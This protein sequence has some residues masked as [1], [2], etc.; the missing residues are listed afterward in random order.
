MSLLVLG[1]TKL[2]GRALVEAALAAGDRG[3][4]ARPDGAVHVLGLLGVTPQEVPLWFPDGDGWSRVDAGRAPAAGLRLRSLGDTVAAARQQ[5]PLVDGIGL[6]P[7]REAELL[8][9][10]HAR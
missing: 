3:R 1:G 9:A 4:R 10:W 7:E 6:G 2:V 5:A 8:A